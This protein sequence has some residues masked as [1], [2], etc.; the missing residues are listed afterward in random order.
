MWILE[1]EDIVAHLLRKR[2]AI[3]ALIDDTDDADNIGWK[4]VLKEVQSGERTT[5]FEDA[6]SA[7]DLIGEFDEGFGPTYWEA[8]LVETLTI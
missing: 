5:N 4:Q 8:Y 3:V 6:A 2:L 1:T 7:E